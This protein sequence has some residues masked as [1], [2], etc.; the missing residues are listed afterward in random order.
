MKSVYIFFA[1]LACL[2][3]SAQKNSSLGFLELTYAVII[4][5][6]SGDLQL[7]EV[8]VKDLEQ[9]LTQHEKDFN[10]FNAL[11]KINT[12]KGRLA[13][14]RGDIDSA[15]KFLL[16]SIKIQNTP[17]LQ[18]FGPNMSLAR[19]LLEEGELSV[20]LEYLSLCKL[21]WDEKY[22]KIDLWIKD[23]KRNKNPDFGA[24]LYL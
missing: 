4:T 9:R 1:I 14:S 2:D 15:K 21:I 11:H 16:N 20:V 6:D 22:S 17:Q 23:I 13:L 3:V 18:T 19:D 8:H 24:H 10:Y 5:I 7:A 12:A